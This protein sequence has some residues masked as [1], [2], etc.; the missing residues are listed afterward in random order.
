MSTIAQRQKLRALLKKK[1][2]KL[3]MKA[4]ATEGL[5]IVNTEI[6]HQRKIMKT[7]GG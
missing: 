5:K 6:A 3:I 4:K 1:D 2:D 7:K